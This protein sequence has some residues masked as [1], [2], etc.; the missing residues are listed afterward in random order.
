MFW[1]A[2]NIKEDLSNFPKPALCE[3]VRLLTF[4]R[5]LNHPAI[6][7]GQKFRRLFSRRKHPVQVE[8]V[9]FAVK[10]SK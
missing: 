4:A 7:I 2:T 8:L 6:Q 10:H 5:A 9:I 1:D 3:T